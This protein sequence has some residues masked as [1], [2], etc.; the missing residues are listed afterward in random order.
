M[1]KYKADRGG[2]TKDGQVMFITEVV[3]DLNRGVELETEVFELRAHIYRLRIALDNTL[4]IC[5]VCGRQDMKDYQD[6]KEVH[7]E[8]PA[9]SLAAHNSRIEE[10]AIERCKAEVEKYYG[11]GAGSIAIHGMP[12]KYTVDDNA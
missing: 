11:G 1:D 6:A 9:Q 8:E 10:E 7:T 12:R 2:I 3:K 5:E 4:E